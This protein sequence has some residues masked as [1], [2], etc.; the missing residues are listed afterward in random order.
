MDY[1]CSSGG[2][3][4]AAI[5]SQ[6]NALAVVGYLLEQNSVLANKKDLSGISPIYLAC[7]T[8]QE[9]IVKLLLQNG[10]DPLLCDKKAMPLH[11]C[12]QKNLT[13]IGKLLLSRS[14]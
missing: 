7:Y 13:E 14:P 4:H 12:A 5:T 8:Q 6:R 2:P 9:A 11:Y 1:V 3:L 10:A